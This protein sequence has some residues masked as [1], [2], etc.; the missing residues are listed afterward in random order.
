MRSARRHVVH[1]SF[2]NLLKPDTIIEIISPQCLGMRLAESGTYRPDDHQ[3][4]IIAV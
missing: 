1:I 4:K 3:C 2:K